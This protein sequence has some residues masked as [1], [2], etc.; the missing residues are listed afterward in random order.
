MR[1]LD[2]VG[3]Y[4]RSIDEASKIYTRLGF[5]VEKVI[6]FDAGGRAVPIAFI[7]VAPGVDIEL[8]EAPAA[9]D[10]GVEPLHHVCFTVEDISSEL[11]AL[12]AEG[13][14]VAD[15][16]PRPGAAARLIAFLQPEAAH[17]VRVELAEK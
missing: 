7:P 3:I 14:P 11:S 16:A 13:V 9:L 10:A 2:H 12:K 5:P 17:G 4:V 6:Q 8:I 15:H 1:Q